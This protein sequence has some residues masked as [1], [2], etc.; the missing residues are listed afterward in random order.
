MFALEVHPAQELAQA[1]R[2]AGLGKEEY[3]G[4]RYKRIAHLQRMMAEGRI[5]SSLRW[6]SKQVA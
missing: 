3:E 6:R 2:A 5:D 1:Y 4:P